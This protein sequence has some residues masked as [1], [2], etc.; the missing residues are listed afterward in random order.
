MAASRPRWCIGTRT[1][2]PRRAAAIVIDLAPGMMAPDEV[3]EE[4]PPG[5]EQVQADASP[6]QKVEQVEE[7]VEEK[8]RDQGRAGAAARD[9]AGAQSGGRAGAAAAEARAAS[10]CRPEKQAPAPETTAPQ[11]PKS[12]SRQVAA[13]PVQAQLNVTDSNAIPTWQKLVVAL[14]ER[15]KRYPAAARRTTTAALR[16]SPSASTGRAG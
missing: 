8:I 1:T 2:T 5:P 13:A 15:N 16:S 11:V 14:L 12:R 7:Q 6:E 10:S 3:R 9:R 4:L